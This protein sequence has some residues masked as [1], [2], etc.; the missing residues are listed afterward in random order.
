MFVLSADVTKPSA[1]LAKMGLKA[2]DI[3]PPDVLAKYDPAM[4]KYV[5]DAK[6]AGVPAQHEF[7][8]EQVRADPARFAATWSKD[9]SGYERVA[10]HAATKILGGQ[11][12]Q[13]QSSRTQKGQTGQRRWR[14]GHGHL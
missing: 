2:E 9:V 4:V 1:G 14:H 12:S 7:P 13:G 10:E 11:S 3:F 8:V 5:L 6:E